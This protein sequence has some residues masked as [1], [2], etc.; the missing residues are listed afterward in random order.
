MSRSEFQKYKN[1]N[2]SIKIII[3]GDSGTGK[4]T[5]C[6][7]WMKNVFTEEYQVTIL[8]DFSYKIYEYKGKY[9]KIQFWDIGGQDKN[10]ISL[11]LF[12]KNAYGCI[13][14]S[15]INEP[16]TLNK[17]LLWKK[18]I[19]DNTQFINGEKIPIVIVQNKIDLVNNDFLNNTVQDIINFSQDNGFIQYFRTSC[20]NDINVNECMDFLLS[21]IIDK[22]EEFNKNKKENNDGDYIGNSIVVQNPSTEIQL[23]LAKKNKKCCYYF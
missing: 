8:S 5:F 16:Q 3:V 7:R 23:T 17:S 6:N 20:K 4:T 1:C 12:C 11:K 13:I 2:T 10:I 21:N 22:V 14:L 15:D 9:Y 19:E 18:E